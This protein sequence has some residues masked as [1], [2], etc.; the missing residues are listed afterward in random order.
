MPGPLPKEQRRRRNAPAIPTTSLP[1]EGRQGPPPEIP[2]G[3]ELGVTGLAWWEWVW[4]TPQAAGWASGHE[5]AVARRASLEDDLAALRDVDGL[6]FGDVLGG[7]WPAVRSAIQCLASLATGRLGILRQMDALD[8]R[9]GLTPK[10][11]AALRWSIKAAEE[12]APAAEDDGTL[13][14]VH[15]LHAVG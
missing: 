4:H 2:V 8:D 3:V 9:L 5:A 6:D 13:A 7:E 15:A 12:D 10:S 11:M 1:A 14:A